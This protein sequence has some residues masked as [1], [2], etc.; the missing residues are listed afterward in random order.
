M[1]MRRLTLHELRSLASQHD[2][3]CI[4]LFVDLYPSA[5]RRESPR[6]RLDRLVDRARQLVVTQHSRAE[7]T[8]LLKP[9]ARAPEELRPRRA[10]IAMFRSPDWFAIYLVPARIHDLVV[11]A[12]TFHTRPLVTYLNSARTFLV[13][14]LHPRGARLL[15]G[16]PH[17]LV[18]I[19]AFPRPNA[20]SSSR[21]GAATRTRDEY[22]RAVD[23]VVAS[24]LAGDRTPVVLAGSPA[25]QARYRAV[26]SAVEPLERGVRTDAGHA[27]RRS[28]RVRALAIADEHAAIV[29]GELLGQVASAS[30]RA[31]FDLAQIARAAVD[32]R[33]RAF[34]HA[35]DVHVWGTL[36][37][38]SG[39]IAVH[40]HQRDATDADLLDD[41]AETVLLGGGDVFAVARDEIPG[42]H[43]AAALYSASPPEAADLAVSA[44][45]EPASGAAASHPGRP[46]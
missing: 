22:F 10:S 11:V 37:R 12:T 14:W 29:K 3:P 30:A 43:P 26:A 35:D 34:I 7:A 24:F 17:D 40:E 42:G 38:A 18:E 9:L 27:S 41:V 46:R 39:A 21:G 1:A 15:A 5:H 32:G 13:L 16:T 20:P 45:R 33:V 23:S 2:P 44:K 25:A 36:D 28:L 8:A 19:D 31:T 6:R 4:S